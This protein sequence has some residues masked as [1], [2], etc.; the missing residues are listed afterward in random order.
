MRHLRHLN[1]TI[2]T[3]VQ[4]T[5]A[6]DQARAYIAAQLRDM[7]Y[8]PQVQPFEIT[9]KNKAGETRQVKSANVMAVQPGKSEQEIVVVAHLDSVAAGLGADDNASGVGVLLEAAQALHGQQLPYT[10]RFLAAGAEEGYSDGVQN[11][12]RNGG[13]NGSSF[14]VGQ[15]SPEAL[16][17]TLF[18]VNL[19]S[20]AAGDVL[21]V[22]GSEGADG[23]V[24]DAA[25]QL[26]QRLGYDLQTSP[27]LADEFPA[28]STGD[29]SDHAPFAAK[30][31]PYAYFE[32]TNWSLGDK[33]GYT[34]T[35][36]HGGIW[37]TA[38]DNLAF[39]NREFPGRTEAHL[40]A[41][42][43]VLIHLLE[44]PPTR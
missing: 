35:V 21:N 40:K 29:W 44:A 24:R 32:A 9:R 31:I 30:G 15:L 38:K 3:R 22:Y 26:G 28:G 4:G 8:Q 43:D 37:H 6:E 5:A 2:G 36:K 13:I 20:L 11:G 7:G 14:Y 16:H 42:S 10:V 18:V 1:D 27:G 34:Q 23:Y 33:D 12:F 25:L 41:F 17:K 19:D 39:L